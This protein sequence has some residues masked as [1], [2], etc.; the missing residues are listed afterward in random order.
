[1][2]NWTISNKQ[3]ELL[4]SLFQGIEGEVKEVLDLGSGRTSIF[5]LADRYPGLTIKGVIYPG[6]TRKIDPIKEC[7]KNPNYEL[8]ESDIKDLN[9]NTQYDIVLAHLLLGEAEKFGGNR[10]EEILNKLFDIKTRY[11]VLVNLFRDNV[12]YNLLLTK[13][14]DKG[15]I[16]KLAHVRSD[17]SN[18]DCLGIVILFPR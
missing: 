10:F 9:P 18:D 17:N 1:M 13:I 11:L 14:A 3:K 2:N 5:Y 6:D 4:D 16:I 15:S 12:N 7:V 8:I